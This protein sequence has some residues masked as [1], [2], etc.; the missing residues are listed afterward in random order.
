MIHEHQKALA[1]FN[2]SRS[3][4]H[5]WR[6]S[7]WHAYQGTSLSFSRCLALRT[8]RANHGQKLD[9]LERLTVN[10]T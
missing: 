5:S 3:A 8:W 10:K 6:L 7:A 2:V 1:L 9:Y 4:G